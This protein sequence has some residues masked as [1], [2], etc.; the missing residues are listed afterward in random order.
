MKKLMVGKSVAFPLNNGNVVG[1]IVEIEEST[2]VVASELDQTV[3]YRIPIMFALN[4]KTF[5]IK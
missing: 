2:I 1:K 5:K 3:R 4:S